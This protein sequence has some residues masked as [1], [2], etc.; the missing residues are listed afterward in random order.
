MRSTLRMTH[1]EVVVLTK[2]ITCV[3]L[4]WFKGFLTTSHYKGMETNVT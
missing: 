1:V 3:M 2:P 4:G